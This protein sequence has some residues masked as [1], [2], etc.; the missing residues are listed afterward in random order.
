MAAVAADVRG[1]TEG[2]HYGRPFAWHQQAAQRRLRCRLGR[3]RRRGAGDIQRVRSVRKPGRPPAHRGT[4]Q[5]PATRQRA[6]GRAARARPRQLSL[7]EHRRRLQRPQRPTSDR[8]NR[9]G[10]ARVAAGAG[11]RLRLRVVSLYNRLSLREIREV[12]LQGQM[13][14]IAAVWQ[15]RPY[16][17]FVR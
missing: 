6:L 1:L 8:R 10:V 15:W 11:T 4:G 14:A 17:S 2:R 16:S 9:R 13:L 5:S 3:P 7:R 12:D